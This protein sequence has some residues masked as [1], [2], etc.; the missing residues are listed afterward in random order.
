MSALSSLE[1][2]FCATF[3]AGSKIWSALGTAMCG[4]QES[5]GR[6]GIRRKILASLKVD[7]R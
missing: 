2:L 7:V 5:I 1:V 6:R 4:S 3:D